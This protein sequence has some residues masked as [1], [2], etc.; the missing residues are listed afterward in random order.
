MRRIG[1]AI[2]AL[3]LAACGS[4]TL[5][6]HG[7]GLARLTEPPSAPF[8]MFVSVANDDSFH[9]VAVANIAALDR[10][11]YVT[12]L[13]C[14]RVYF[15]GSRGICLMAETAGRDTAWLAQLF[16]EQFH[17][18]QKLPL[19]GTPSRVRLSPDGRR[20]AA[21]VFESGHAYDEH[22]FAT[23]TT[24]IDTVAGASLGDLEQFTTFRDGQVF[25]AVD[26]NFWGATF[27]ADNDA[28]FA[29][30]QTGSISYLVK[31][32]VGKR[33]LEV[34]RPGVECPSISPDNTRIAFK[35]RVGTQARGWWQIA[36]LSL[37]TLQDSLISTE[38]RSVDDQVE[39]IDNDRVAYHLTG[40]ETAADLWAVRVDGS[41][42]PQR[43][44]ASA[45]SPAVVRQASHSK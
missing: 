24:I 30:L 14:E 4:R 29:T 1:A 3:L 38:S 11:A 10:G 13:S 27:A 2:G 9:R 31:G 17:A 20:A 15:S 44:L 32:S 18:L 33:R 26:F 21:T 45:Y 43:L 40:G 23:R 42:P 37:D 8:L 12:N 28:F 34:L 16:D 22:G 6:P 41:A 36:V 25:R 39:W 19:T 35:K 5:P 7:A